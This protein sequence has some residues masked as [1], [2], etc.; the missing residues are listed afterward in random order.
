MSYDFLRYEVGDKIATIT[1]NRPEVRNALS[2]ALIDELHDAIRA[3][4]EAEDVHVIIIRGAGDHFCS[5]HDLSESGLRD[6]V[7]R[8]PNLECLWE[9][10]EDQYLHKHGLDIWYTDTPTIAEVQG[11]AVLGGFVLANVCDIVV[12]GDNA[13]FW[14][15]ALRMYN[16]GAEVLM[17]PWVMGHRKAKEFLFTG[18]RMGAE[19]AYK[20]GMVNHVVPVSELTSMTREIAAKIARQPR[21]ALK[22]AKRAVNKTLDFQGFNAAMEHAFLLHV[23]GHGT[24]AFQDELWKPMLKKVDESGFSSYLAERDAK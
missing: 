6:Y 21:I 7:D 8:A 9:M 2:F 1:L 11:V 23:I 19:E 16:M 18:D 5:G 20:Y 12:A 14:V 24:A 13:E 4:D 3:A 15:P 10:E 22:L 17:E